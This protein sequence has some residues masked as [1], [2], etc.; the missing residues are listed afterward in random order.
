M[1]KDFKIGIVVGLFVAVL[2]VVYF[3]VP[4][5]GKAPPPEQQADSK[6]GREVKKPTVRIG[7]NPPAPSEEPGPAVGP[8]RT[9][10]AE[11]IVP[12]ISQVPAELPG[13]TIP[14]KPVIHQPLAPAPGPEQIPARETGRVPL[15]P[16]FPSLVPPGEA[17]VAELPSGERTYVVKEGDHGFWT[18]AEKVYGHGRYW[19][20]IAKANPALESRSL[21]VGQKLVIPPLPGRT[22]TRAGEGVQP[23]LAAGESRGTYT[24]QKGDNGFWGVAEKVYGNGGH[25]LLIE[26]AN[27]GMDPLR[28]Q[29]GQKLV[30]P[31]LPGTTAPVAPR[32]REA[33]TP[34]PPAEEKARPAEG[35][36][37]R[38]PSMNMSS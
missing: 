1:R 28:L 5:G 38:P 12:K 31:P 36:Y 11:V 25:Y 4:R 10:P 22:A 9:A 3:V 33:G 26:R 2:A 18:V 16:R 7:L 27:P 8:E 19:A 13:E 17:G 14:V 37:V 32:V 35:R 24:V 20:Q 29:P 21:P 6:G 15:A 23:V 30:I 34:P